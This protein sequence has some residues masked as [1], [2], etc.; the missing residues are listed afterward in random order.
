MELLTVNGLLAAQ[1]LCNTINLVINEFSGLF[2]ISTGRTSLATAG[3]RTLSLTKR[4]G[5]QTF[6]HSPTR[7]HLTGN[8]G[9][10]L[11]VIFCARGNTVKHHLLGSTSPKGR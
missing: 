7:D 8:H 3:K 10:A 11:Q 4:D 1:L 6:A 5:S 2:T 9:N